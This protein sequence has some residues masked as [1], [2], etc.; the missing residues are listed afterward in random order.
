MTAL[1][2]SLDDLIGEAQNLRA[3]LPE[4][5]D[6]HASPHEVHDYLLDVRRRLDRVEHLFAV[7]IRVHARTKRSAAQIT[8]ELDDAWDEAILKVRTAPVR[9][10]DEYSSAKERAAEAN[11]VTLAA[12]RAART[13]AEN[14][15]RADEALAVLRL[16]HRGLDG[17]RQDALTILRALVFESHLER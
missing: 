4:M 15:L 10:G 13:A 6:T 17:V 8:A 12:R 1:A 9:R 11:L 2:S 7:C 5:P 14:V 16:L 3:A